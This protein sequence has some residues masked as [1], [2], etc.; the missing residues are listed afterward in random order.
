MSTQ[1]NVAQAIEYFRAGSACSQAVLATYF[2]VLGL[3]GRLGHKMAT[4]LGAGLGRKQYVCGAVNA[5]AIILSLLYG[6]EEA[7]QIDSKENTYAK[8]SNFLDE[9]ERE[10]EAAQCR[11]LLGVKLA[12]E[13]GRQKAKAMNLIDTKCVSYVTK[14]CELLEKELESTK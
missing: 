1:A 3:D 14:V 9:F 8:V 11:E 2:Q 12:T 6:S 10:F 5:G 13:E 7:R 4:G